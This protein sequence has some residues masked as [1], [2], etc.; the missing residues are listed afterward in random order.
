MNR[1][2][3]AA[4][5]LHGFVRLLCLLVRVRTRFS[6]FDGFAQM[7]DIVYRADGNEHISIIELHNG[8]I[9]V[10]IPTKELIAFRTPRR[11]HV[12]VPTATFAWGE[13][14]FNLLEHRQQMPAI[15]LKARIVWLEVGPTDVVPREQCA[16]LEEQNAGATG[17]IESIHVA[18]AQVI[19]LT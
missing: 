18:E 7:L 15:G 4:V 14:G 5:G 1:G 12:A 3:V 16:I 13:Q 9:L 2:C 8:F 6:T 17:A 10:Q 19:H 11:I